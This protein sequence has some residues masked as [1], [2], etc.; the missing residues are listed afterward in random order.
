M[1]QTVS[2]ARST[3]DPRRAPSSSEERAPVTPDSIFQVAFGFA[4]SKTLLSAVELGLFTHLARTPQDLAS[5][6]ENLGL[7]PRSAAD[8]FDTLV[9]L[10]LLGRDE[11]GRYHNS[12]EAERFLDRAKPDYLGG[13]LEMS[14]ARLYGFWG[15]LTEALRTGKPQNEA[16]DH[17]DFFQTLYGE[18]DRLAEFLKA[19]TGLS[20][21]SGRAIAQKFDWRP[22]RAFVDV[23]TAE[24]A[25][26]VQ[27]ALAHDHLTGAGMD[28]PQV[29]PLYERYVRAHGLSDRLSFQQRDFF[30]QPLPH[31]DV[32]IMGHIL[33]DWGLDTKRMLVKKAYEALPAGGA[34]IVFDAMIDNERRRATA[35]LLMSLNMLI[36]TPDGFDYT[37]GQCQAW[38]GEAGFRQVRVEPLLG[39]DW[40]AVGYK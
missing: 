4:A 17:P 33:H 27:L 24:G 5:L 6:T 15:R 38:L 23:G 12:P 32:I 7:H 3:S 10:R 1:S 36:E 13:M 31:A 25:I 8:F 34:F 39:H 21:G 9:S 16:K 35:G 40:M 18:P 14:N 37:T 2:G 20:R 28:L 26:P 11:H 29:R 22:Y 19:M 30:K